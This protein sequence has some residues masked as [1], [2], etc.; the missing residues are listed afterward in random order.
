[1][2]FLFGA[3]PIFGGLIQ[4]RVTNAVTVISSSP[5]F[6]R[7]RRDAKLGEDPRKDIG[8][9]WRAGNDGGESTVLHGRGG[10]KKWKPPVILG[11]ESSHIFGNW[12]IT[13]RWWFQTFFIFTPTWGNHPISLIF[14]RWVGSTTNQL[15]LFSLEVLLLWT[16]FWM[17]PV[18][19][20]G[21]R[22]TI[23]ASAS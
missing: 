17:V 14:F 3:R 23:T 4:T 22:V 13:T 11:F 12:L 8:G 7:S 6:F 10:H 19:P 9:L 21:L 1:M 15:W 5:L 2:K 16:R 20:N 18:W